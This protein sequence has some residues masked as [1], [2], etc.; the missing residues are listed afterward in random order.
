[1]HPDRVVALDEIGL[2]AVAR[3]ELV[4]VPV[5][6]AAEDRRAGDLVSVEMQDREDRA[7][8]DGAQDLVGVP[9]GR[10]RASLGFAVT[11]DAGN[12]QIGVVEGGP[13]GMNERV[14]E[15]TALVDGPG[16]LRRRMARNAAR[17]RE[18]PEEP[19]QALLVPA[20]LRID[21]AVGAFEIGV[22]HHTR[23][24]VPGTADIDHAEIAGSDHPIEMCID[25]VQPGRRPPMAQQPGLDM[26]GLER[27]AQ[28]RIVEQIDLAD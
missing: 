2:V 15:F 23:T 4:Q 11:H 17:K 16:R 18:L 20:D 24:S 25:E 5:A 12:D 27:L 22:G 21:L 9:G 14:A 1:M 3:E 26:L 28:Q 6:H 19:L 13:V 10:Q 7:V 8:R